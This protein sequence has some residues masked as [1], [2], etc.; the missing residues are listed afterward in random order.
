MNKKEFFNCNLSDSQATVL[1]PVSINNFDIY[2]YADYEA[3]L[4]ERC[5]DFWESDTGIL[6]YRRMRVAEI[7][8][9]DCKDIKKSLEWQLGALKKSMEFKADIPNFLEPWYG[10]GTVAGSFGFDYSL[11]KNQATQVDGKFTLTQEALNFNKMPVSETPIGKH[12]LNMMEYILKKTRG[13]LP[14]SFCDVQ[15]PL[16]VAGNIVDINNFF[17]DFYLNPNNVRQ[18]LDN[19]ADLIINFTLQQVKLLRETLVYPRHGFAS[20]R[21]FEGLG[22]SDD[23][24]VMLSDDLYKETARP[25]FEKTAIPFGNSALHSC[26]NWSKKNPCSKKD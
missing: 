16:N 7:F 15:S 9:Y 4:L 19:I 26:G 23:L 8:S 5:K 20:C 11:I 6:V 24:F 12:T 10:I 25:I 13:K 17:T 18:L 21:K 22:M 14:V 2:K 1:E 3:T